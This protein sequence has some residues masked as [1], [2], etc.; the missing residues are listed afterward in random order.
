MFFYLKCN[1]PVTTKHVLM[2]TPFHSNFGTCVF[3]PWAFDVDGPFGLQLSTWITIK[4]FPVDDLQLVHM[5]H[6]EAGEVLGCDMANASLKHPKFCVSVNVKQG[7]IAEVEL[8]TFTPRVHSQ[9]II[10]YDSLPI[11]CHFYLST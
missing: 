1:S 9:T 11:I 4:R 3:H 10:D 6:T 2:Q 7:S 8:I 5:V